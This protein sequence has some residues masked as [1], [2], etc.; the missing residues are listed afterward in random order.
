MPILGYFHNHFPQ[1]AT[2]LPQPQRV[3]VF[4]WVNLGRD[5]S[6]SI[7][8]ELRGDFCFW[9]LVDGVMPLIFVYVNAVQLTKVHRYTM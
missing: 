8:A 5:R 9:T 1:L 6:L 7:Q 3:S 2:D 4:Q